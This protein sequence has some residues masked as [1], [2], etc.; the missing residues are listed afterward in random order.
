MLET[1][2]DI[3][4]IPEKLRQDNSLLKVI[5]EATKRENDM[6]EAKIRDCSDFEPGWPGY[7]S[8]LPFE[9]YMQSN[10]DSKTLLLPLL[11]ESELEE[12]A[13]RYLG[14]QSPKEFQN[15]IP[16]LEKIKQKYGTGFLSLGYLADSIIQHLTDCKAEVTA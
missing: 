16:A 10:P 2:I 1:I 14:R 5:E 4:K 15:C 12:E 7:N 13:T 9:E 6:I 8:F 3:K 11:L